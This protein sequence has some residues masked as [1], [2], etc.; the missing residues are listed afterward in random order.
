MKKKGENLATKEDLGD[1]VEQTRQLTNT[2]KEIESKIDDQVWSRQRQWELKRD[3]LLEFCQAMMRF[4][5]AIMDLSVKIR[6]RTLTPKT[7]ESFNSALAI[8]NETSSA[9]ERQIFLVGLVLDVSN[10]TSLMNL[11]KAL[12]DA[13]TAIL[14]SN[15]PV[16]DPN[17]NVYRQ[18]QKTIV[19]GIEG[20]RR[21]VRDELGFTPRSGESSA[22]PNPD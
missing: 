3:I 1:L 5:G 21:I 17:T 16:A 7:S 20:M 11:N 18:Y 10:R 15:F 4:D 22:A 14:E 6:S 12:R 2:A 8:W 13:T 9:F 19:E